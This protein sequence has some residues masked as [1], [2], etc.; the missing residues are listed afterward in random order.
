MSAQHQPLNTQGLLGRRADLLVYPEVFF[1]VD[2]HAVEPVDDAELAASAENPNV[3]TVYFRENVRDFV[4][5]Q[6][7]EIGRVVRLFA[8][9]H[10]SIPP[11]S[12]SLRQGCAR[13]NTQRNTIFRHNQVFLAAGQLR[14][15]YRGNYA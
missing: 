12:K 11:T 5:D 14:G 10:C 1:R 3:W 15:F 4:F 2:D 6:A 7:I 9:S 8:H 13:L